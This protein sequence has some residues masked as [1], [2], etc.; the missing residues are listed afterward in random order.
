MQKADSFVNEMKVGRGLF[1][2]RKETLW[3]R[4]K[5]QD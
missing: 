5:I 2:K 1:G 3:R 4:R